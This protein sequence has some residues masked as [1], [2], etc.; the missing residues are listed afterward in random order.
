MQGAWFIYLVYY[1][2]SNSVFHFSINTLVFWK[3][4]GKVSTLRWVCSVFSSIPPIFGH[5]SEVDFDRKCVKFIDVFIF[6][7]ENQNV[8][9]VFLLNHPMLEKTV[10]MSICINFQIKVM[11]VACEKTYW[12]KLKFHNTHRKVKNIIRCV[13]TLVIMHPIFMH[14]PKKISFKSA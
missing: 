3:K 14:L 2:K 4:D 6:T 12:L 10:K 7:T 1:I 13:F 8:F 11:K 5:I 9:A